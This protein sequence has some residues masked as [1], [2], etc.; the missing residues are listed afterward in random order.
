MNIKI[1]YYQQTNNINQQSVVVDE[2]V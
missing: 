1:T 2:N